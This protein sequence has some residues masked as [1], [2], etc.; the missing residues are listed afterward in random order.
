MG[1]V[2]SF[3]DRGVSVPEQPP[4]DETTK[5]QLS[6]GFTRIVNSVMD[7]WPSAR[8]SSYELAMCIA[9]A[10]R[11]FGFNKAKDRIAASQLAE[12][13]Q[14]TRPKASSTLNKLLRKNVVIREGGSHGPIKINTRTDQWLRPEKGTKPPEQTPKT[15][16][17]DKNGTPSPNRERK[18][19]PKR[20][21]T[22]DNKQTTKNTTCSSVDHPES[23]PSSTAEQ[24]PAKTNQ[25]P[26]AA[27]QSPNGKKW[28]YEIDLEMATAMGELIDSRLG[29]D[30]PANRNLLSWAN[31][32][33]LMREA[34]NRPAKAILAL[35]AWAQ[36][37]QFWKTNILSP[38]KLRKQWA[39][40]AAQRNEQ[41]K[42]NGNE[43]AAQ[44]QRAASRHELDRQLTDYDY[45]R[46]NF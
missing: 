5:P 17:G 30:A 27:I 36:Q 6:D 7:A 3:P 29:Q 37:D 26:G 16:Q 12:D 1:A 42:G 18:T 11:T 35:F 20:E 31:E 4:N 46:K 41:R 10:R 13:M 15:E 38:A 32:L 45:A 34:D 39:T 40:L 43:R 19:C 9:I 22:K 25:K 8:L 44:N 2:Y 23:T 24:L 21:H 28:G 33:R 14:I